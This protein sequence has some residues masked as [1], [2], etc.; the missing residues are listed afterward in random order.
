VSKYLQRP[1]P[2]VRKWSTVEIF[3]C[4][5]WLFGFK[6]DVKILHFFSGPRRFSQEFETGLNARVL[7]KAINPNAIGQFFPS[8]FLLQLDD[9]FLE[10][11]SV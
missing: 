9:D 3:I 8:V 10:G 11:D 1:H 5:L 4:V 7:V 2:E 6:T